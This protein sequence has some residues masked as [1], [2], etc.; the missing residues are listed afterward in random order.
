MFNKYVLG[1]HTE[2]S[3]IYFFATLTI[4]NYAFAVCSWHAIL[5]VRLDNEDF[6]P[7]WY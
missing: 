4:V 6:I 5:T 3:W 2:V 7:D 1:V